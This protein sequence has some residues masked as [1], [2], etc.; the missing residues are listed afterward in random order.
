MNNRQADKL[1]KCHQRC[2]LAYDDAKCLSIFL[3]LWS[4]V[5]THHLYTRDRSFCSLCLVSSNSSGQQTMLESLLLL[6]LF[7]CVVHQVHS[8]D[9]VCPPGTEYIESTKKCILLTSSPCDFMTCVHECEKN[10]S[11]VLS[12]ESDSERSVIYHKY[13]ENKLSSRMNQRY[14]HN[15]GEPMVWLN[16]VRISTDLYTNNA[17]RRLDGQRIKYSNWLPNNP[18]MAEGQ[19]C[20]VLNSDNGHFDDYWCERT[21]VNCLCESVKSKH[22]QVKPL[23]N[24]RI[25]DRFVLQLIREKIILSDHI[26]HSGTWI[27]LLII[28]IVIFSLLV[29]FLC[30]F[31]SHSSS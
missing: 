31:N 1:I 25:T 24:S 17:F 20:A 3:S 5:S 21:Y 10:A 27:L 18:D 8:L 9:K 4:S 30:K 11:S 28:L 23:D 15:Y 16:M 26:N 2:Q 13:L 6:L 29:A 19:A 12:V 14:D 22:P 7:S